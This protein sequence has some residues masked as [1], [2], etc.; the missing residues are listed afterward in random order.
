[1]GLI[2]ELSARAG[3]MACDAKPLVVRLE[4][5]LSRHRDDGGQNSLED[6]RT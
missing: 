4:P 3:H 1:M 2:P 6:S 5:D